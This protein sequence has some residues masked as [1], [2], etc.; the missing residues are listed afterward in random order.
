MIQDVCCSILDQLGRVIPPHIIYNQVIYHNT[1][2]FL[3]S[4]TTPD[5]SC[6]LAP[7][8]PQPRSCT[9]ALPVPRYLITSTCD[10]TQVQ[11]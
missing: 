8:F 5:H 4:N 2:A 6:L 11:L 10:L 9:S 7:G 3:L 1:G